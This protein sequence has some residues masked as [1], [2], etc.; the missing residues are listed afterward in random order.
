MEY[1]CHNFLPALKN[2]PKFF[3]P[4]NTSQTPFTRGRGDIRKPNF[5]FIFTKKS[6][7][8]CNPSI[9]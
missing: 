9:T 4:K 2:P 3:Q 6:P 1:H 5:F 8:T 7:F